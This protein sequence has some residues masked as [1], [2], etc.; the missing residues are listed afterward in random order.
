MFI[1]I[2]FFL[3]IKKK[4]HTHSLLWEYR[5]FILISNKCYFDDNYQIHFYLSVRN[6]LFKKRERERRKKLAHV[7]YMQT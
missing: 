3:D 5:L 6:Y 7:Y 2:L 4:T 1:K